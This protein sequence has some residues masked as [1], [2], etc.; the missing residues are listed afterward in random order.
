MQVVKWREPGA[1]QLVFLDVTIF[2]SEVI[3]N[4]AKQVEH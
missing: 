2:S 1:D 4:E 3:K